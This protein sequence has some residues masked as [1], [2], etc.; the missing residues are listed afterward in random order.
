M[1]C[2]W[3]SYTEHSNSSFHFCLCSLISCVVYSNIFLYIAIKGLIFFSHLVK[4]RRARGDFKAPM[5]ADLYLDTKNILSKH[6]VILHSRFLLKMN[7]HL[8]SRQTQ[9]KWEKS[10]HLFQI[11]CSWDIENMINVH[12]VSNSV[13]ISLGASL[14]L[15]ATLS[16]KQ[17]FCPYSRL[18]INP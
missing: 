16:C 13:T 4:S 11:F 14:L 2:Y 6:T 17:N 12:K 5:T 8:D 7:P 15:F 3:C 10:F 18:I 9:S 1:I